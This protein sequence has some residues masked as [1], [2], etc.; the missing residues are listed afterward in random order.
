[1][2]P[3]PPTGSGRI[4]PRVVADVAADRADLVLGRRR[5]T[6]SGA[7]PV[8]ARIGNAAVAW[9][10]RRRGGAAVRDLGPMRAARRQ[11]L[12]DLNLSDRRFGY[13]ME[14]ILKA[15]RSRWRMSEVDVD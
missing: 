14:M 1:M 11:A 3:L 13:P 12:L 10:L 5:P 9:R 4:C 2:S 6:R 8:H 15:T 7:W